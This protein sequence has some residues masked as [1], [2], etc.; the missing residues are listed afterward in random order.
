MTLTRR[1]L[2]AGLASGLGEATLAQGAR[3][4]TLGRA[5]AA[6]VPAMVTNA[7]AA[8][9]SARVGAP[10]A[11]DLIRAADLGGDVAYA[12]ADARTG[13]VLETRAGGKALPPASTAK[14]ITALYALDTLHAEARFK[15]RLIAT[16]PISGGQIRGD[17]ILAGGGD[18]TLDTDDLA[19]MA[20]ALRARGVTGI[21]GRFLVWAGALPFAHEIAGDQ[22]EHVGYNP[23]VSGINLNYNR[24][25]L[26]WARGQNGYRL[27]MDAASEHI[28]P[29]VYSVRVTLA[30]RKSPLFTYAEH[31]GREE[32]T[33]AAASLS[34]RGSRWLPVRRPDLYAGDVF[35]T[36]AR[37]QGTPLPAPQPVQTLPG[38]EVVVDHDSR[39]LRDILREMLKYSNNMTAEAVGMAASL[40]RGQRGD[41]RASARAMTDW[42]RSAS[43]AQGAR[44]VDHSG[45]G[46]ASR[47]P[48]AEMV[49]AI[50]GLGGRAGLRPILKRIP[51]RDAQG[52]VQDNHP[53]RVDAKT[54]TLNFVSTLTGY[55]TAPDGTDLVF[56]ISTANMGLRQAAG[57]V[58]RPEGS[59]A[60]VGRSKRLQQQL[61]ERWGMVYGR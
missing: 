10:S 18:P 32:W 37:A 26:V 15:T 55:M 60:W 39:A 41:I 12:L 24:V 47:I 49:S 58:E 56:A 46:V 28:A 38:G 48:P 14:T 6:L 7:V 19:A 3:L 59:R 29:K 25:Q 31:D 54:G 53:I 13:L 8:P 4:P 22:P 23:A 36:L 52:R 45:L 43:G 44:F 50:V 40:G 27:G 1:M 16:G 51:L 57:R 2:L 17:L 33:V 21:T 20:R 5:G 61:I 34:Q 9:A 30:N 35:Q 11:E 42:L